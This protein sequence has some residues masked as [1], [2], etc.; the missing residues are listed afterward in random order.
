MTQR[1]LG[2]A[3]DGV[4]R[5]DGRTVLSYDQAVDRASDFARKLMEGGDAKA[6]R[7]KAPTIA[8]AIRHY[9]ARK[10]AA[11]Q[12][13]EATTLL[14]RHIPPTLSRAR[15]AELGREDMVT[16]VRGLRPVR[17][18]DL[19]QD[20]VDRICTTMRAALRATG[21]VPEAAL[22]GLRVEAITE[23]RGQRKEA[24]HR[25]ITLTQ[26]QR[27]DFFGVASE[28]AG[29][30]FALFAAVL[31][32]TGVRPGQA[33]SCIVTDLDT[34]ADGAALLSIPK[35]GKGKPRVWKRGR[36]SAPL[37]AT[38]AARISAHVEAL[39]LKSSPRWLDA[40]GMGPRLR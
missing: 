22:K 18:D 6:P 23:A 34:L 40:H 2:T 27:V 32:A 17:G 16:W 15:V 37:P 25:N 9:A 10:K 5:A 14:N 7:Q 36:I 24:S 13:G 20:R 28:V 35:S 38:L 4:L 39:G 26:A 11:G 30:G 8:D 1:V 29:E 33:A 12:A 21:Q 31:D 19:S 3:D